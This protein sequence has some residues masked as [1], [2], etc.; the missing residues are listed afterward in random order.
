M[1]KNEL[2]VA[3]LA[4]VGLT[5]GSVGAAN[6]MAAGCMETCAQVFGSKTTTEYPGYT[7]TETLS[8]CTESANSSGSVITCVYNVSVS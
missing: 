5:L 1:R 6:A 2:V 4:A 8:S 7:E 3:A